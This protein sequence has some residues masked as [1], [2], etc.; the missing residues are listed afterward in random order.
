MENNEIMKLLEEIID[1]EI[2]VDIVNLGLVYGVEQNGN[3]VHVTMTMTSMGCP[4]HK[5]ITDEVRKIIEKRVPGSEVEVEL[6]WDPVWT[7]DM[8]SEQARK[9]LGW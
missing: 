7:P 2:G 8:M 4:L 9:M 1:P 6:V 5:Y 3:H